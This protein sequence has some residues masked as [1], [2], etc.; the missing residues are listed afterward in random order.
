METCWQSCVKY[1]VLIFNLLF[2]LAG[3]IIIGLGA[4]IQIE[5][6]NYLDFLD[7]TYFTIPIL[8]IILGSIIFIIAFF[9]CCGA[10]S[11]KSWMVYVYSV[12]MI[13]VLLGQ[14]GSSIC[15]FVLKVIVNNGPKKCPSPIPIIFNRMTLPIV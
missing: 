9:A 5:G 10:C 2:A 7:S 11:E 15:A 12:L 8:F 1:L 14:F 6:K 3:L 4:Y 13:A